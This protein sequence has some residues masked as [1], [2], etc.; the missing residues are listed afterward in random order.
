VRQNLIF[1]ETALSFSASNPIRWFRI[2]E[3]S[4]H[5]LWQY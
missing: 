1:W 3:S 2:A 5:S 4:V